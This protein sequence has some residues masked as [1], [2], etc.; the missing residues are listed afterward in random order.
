MFWYTLLSV[1]N[2]NF[3]LGG[4]AKKTN[5]N[6]RDY[7]LHIQCLMYCDTSYLIIACYFY[8]RN[9]NF[10]RHEV[11]KTKCLKLTLSALQYPII[12]DESKL[13]GA[14]ALLLGE[15]QEWVD[16]SKRQAKDKVFGRLAVLLRGFTFYPNRFP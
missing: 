7:I 1:R 2:N 4:G 16:L 15:E 10:R 13:H 11:Q 6:G 14:L 3:F 9:K 8:I 12:C 5:F